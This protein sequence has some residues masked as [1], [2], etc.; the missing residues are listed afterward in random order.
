MT[1]HVSRAKRLA[2]AVANINDGLEEAR[3]LQEEMESWRDNMSGTNLEN[4]E[5]YGQ[6]EEAAQT[7]ESAVGEI[8]SAVGELESVEFP[9]M[10]G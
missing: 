10:Y 4:T 5:K 3:S 8:E 6:V 7:L 1:R 9:G 2:Q